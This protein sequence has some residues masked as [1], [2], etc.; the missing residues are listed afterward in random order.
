[1]NYKAYYEY[2]IA[3]QKKTRLRQ[4]EADRMARLKLLIK[5]QNNGN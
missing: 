5:T 4:P 1:M 2:Y 3:R